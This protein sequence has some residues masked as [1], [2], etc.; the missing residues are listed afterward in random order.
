MPVDLRASLK[1]KSLGKPSITN[2]Y[3]MIESLKITIAVWYILDD[4][5]INLL[6]VS[7]SELIFTGCDLLYVIYVIKYN[8]HHDN[9]K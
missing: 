7:W 9:L 5:V 4:L 2:L 6:V 3:T 8:M 1:D